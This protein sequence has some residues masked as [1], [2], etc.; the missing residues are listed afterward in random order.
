MHKKDAGSDL[1]DLAA[2]EQLQVT[3]IPIQSIYASYSPRLTGENIQH[4]RTLAQALDGLPPIIVHRETM[5]V[6]DG[7]HRLLAAQM[8]GE[9]EI[10]VRFF[11]GNENDSYVL[12]VKSNVAHGLP[13]SLADRKAAAARIICLFPAWS[14]R[15][16]ASVTGLSA[17]TV[18]SVRARCKN[19][20][21]SQQSISETRM[22]RD[23]RLRPS[24]MEER[25]QLA[26]SLIRD[27]PDASLRW[28]AERA[29][30]SPE[31]ARNVRATQTA[32]KQ[33]DGHS[34]GPAAT[35]AASS[36][37]TFPDTKK[38]GHRQRLKTL[39]GGKSALDILR[40]DPAFRSSI[41]GRS[42]LQL[43]AFP[44]LLNRYGGNLIAHVP[45][46]CR[47]SVAQAAR[48]CATA[49]GIYASEIESATPNTV[50]AADR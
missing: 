11:E 27:N 38:R 21:P 2:I 17:K 18:A 30:I 7:M 14:D 45:D 42:L 44:S 31:T 15:M 41:T 1:L 39:G 43:L 47:P 49:W 9:T 34:V 26:S 50:P 28:I 5:R 13:L 8:C 25:R 10:E 37:Q 23:G 4:V 3:K 32:D 33:P 40:G 48:E 16:I 22:G 24:N 36:E 12:S 29:G 35:I 19:E 6:I 46:H 20:D